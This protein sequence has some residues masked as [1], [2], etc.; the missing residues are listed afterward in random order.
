[1]MTTEIEIPFDKEYISSFSKEMGE[2]AWLTDLRI[3]ALEASRNLPLP[4]ADKTKIDK[5]NFTQIEKH[6]VKSED[7]SSFDEFPEEVKALIDV[8]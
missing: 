7:F 1:M 5:W 3:H 8:E 2:P 4:R 6:I